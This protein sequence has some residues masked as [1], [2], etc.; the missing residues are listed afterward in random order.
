MKKSSI[1]ENKVIFPSGKQLKFLLRAKE[2]TS[3]SW[4]K[5]ARKIGVP[6]RTLND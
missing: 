2:K 4:T 1:Y 3:L 5:F 6:K